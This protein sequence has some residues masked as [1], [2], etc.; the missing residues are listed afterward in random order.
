[1]K[2]PCCPNTGNIYHVKTRLLLGKSEICDGM[3]LYAANHIP[4][5]EYLGSYVGELIDNQEGSLRGMIYNIAGCS[6]MFDFDEY[7]VINFSPVLI[8]RLWIRIILEIR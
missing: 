8:S 5:G 6:Y 4:K 7:K 2:V 3:G 1:M